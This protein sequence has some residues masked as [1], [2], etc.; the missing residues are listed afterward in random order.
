MIENIISNDIE[1][2]N[3]EEKEKEDNNEEKIDKDNNNNKDNFVDGKNININNIK[4][5]II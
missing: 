1:N 5:N 4:K 3:N 2:N